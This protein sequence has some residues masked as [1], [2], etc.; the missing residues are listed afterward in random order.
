[1]M[2]S[3]KATMKGYNKAR[4]FGSARTPY[5]QQHVIIA[6]LSNLIKQY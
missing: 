3:H 5:N 1:M 6:L 2:V 4:M